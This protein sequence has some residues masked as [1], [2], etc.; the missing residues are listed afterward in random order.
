MLS[1][2]NHGVRYHEQLGFVLP[3][4]S[5]ITGTCSMH[6]PPNTRKCICADSERI[7]AR[8]TLLLLELV[9]LTIKSM[10][11]FHSISAQVTLAE[12]DSTCWTC[13]EEACNVDTTFVRVAT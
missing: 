5:C 4:A 9:S 11:Y 6:Q 2:L 12:P 7:A 1:D 3:P 13:P 8:G 10:L